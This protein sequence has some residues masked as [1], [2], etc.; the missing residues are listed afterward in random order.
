VWNGTDLDLL[1]CDFVDSNE[2]VRLILTD[3]RVVDESADAPKPKGAPKPGKALRKAECHRKIAECLN[4]KTVYDQ[5]VTE[6]SVKNHW[7][8]SA[9]CRSC[10]SWSDRSS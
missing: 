8:T 7:Q 3:K 10:V 6:S 2:D 9:A 1:M 5:F 4:D